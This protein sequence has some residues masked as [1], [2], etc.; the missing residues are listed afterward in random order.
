MTRERKLA[1]QMWEEIKDKIKSDN[2]SMDEIREMKYK[3][4]FEHN[5]GWLHS[6]YFCEYIR[7][8]RFYDTLDLQGCQK[9]PIAKPISRICLNKCG[10]GTF[11]TYSVIINKRY[12]KFIRVM[13][14]NK[15]IKALKKKYK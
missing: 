4:T 13:A 14:C 3:F 11:S 5:L 1:I 7:C 9:C 8:E 6:C 15:I 12:P 2:I 10:C